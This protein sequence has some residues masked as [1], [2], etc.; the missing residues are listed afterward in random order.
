MANP[1]SPSLEPTIIEQLQALTEQFSASIE[2]FNKV[3]TEKENK[4]HTTLALKAVLKK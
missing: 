1:A 2:T 4:M 3:A